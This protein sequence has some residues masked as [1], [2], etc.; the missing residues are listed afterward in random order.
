MSRFKTLNEKELNALDA[1]LRN[2]VDH[3]NQV[4]DVF[5]PD[6]ILDDLAT[7]TSMLQEIRGLR[8]EIINKRNH[9]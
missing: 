3:L 4:L 6:Q 5:G 7:S 8:F 2:Y 9:G 1:A